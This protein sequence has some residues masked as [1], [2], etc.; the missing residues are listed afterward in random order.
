VIVIAGAATFGAGFG[1]LQNATLSLM[2]SRVPAAGYS[3]VSAI[4]NAAYDVGMAIG[5]IGVG[6]LITTTGFSPAFLVTAAAMLP[7]LLMARREGAAMADRSIDMGVE[8]ALA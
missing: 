4:W 5:A 2:Y 7:A 1:I 8:P 6:L 3:T